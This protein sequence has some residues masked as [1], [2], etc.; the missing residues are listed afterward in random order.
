MSGQKISILQQKVAPNALALVH[1][2]D[3]DD[4]DVP[5][6]ESPTTSRVG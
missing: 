1:F 6:T 3:V 5:T 4:R 2:V